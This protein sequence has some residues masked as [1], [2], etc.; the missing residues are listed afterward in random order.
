MAHA[1]DTGPD[2]RD[3]LRIVDRFGAYGRGDGEFYYVTDVA[4]MPAAAGDGPAARPERIYVGEYGGADR[5]SVFDAGHRFM[6]SFGAAGSS[7]DPGDIRFNRPQSLHFDASR[8]ELYVADASN[9]RIG[10]FTPDGEL[11]GVVAVQSVDT[12]RAVAAVRMLRTLH[13]HATGPTG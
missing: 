6:F 12:Q 11:L 9:H 3:A 8:R 4:F 5:V 10:R 13:R 2:G 1:S 7:D